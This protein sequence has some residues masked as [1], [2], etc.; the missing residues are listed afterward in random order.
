MYIRGKPSALHKVVFE[1][2]YRFGYTYLDR[3]GRTINAIMRES[4]EWVPTDQTSPQNTPLIS[5]INKSVFNFS[6]QNLNFAI[7]QPFDSEI[8]DR[9]IAHFKSQVGLVSRI[10]I[11]QLGL[12]EFI[13]IGFRAWY[14]FRCQTKQESEQWLRG[15]GLYSIPESLSAAFGDEIESV[16]LAAIIKGSDRK[17]RIS[18]NGVENLA[19]IDRGSE[20][21]SVRSSI[22]SKDQDKALKKHLQS[23]T[24]QFAAMI[25]ID[26][27]QDDPLQPDPGDFVETSLAQFL[28]RLSSAI[29]SK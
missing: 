18:F 27:F 24:T 3:C 20:I 10:V 13:R 5:F 6:S 21:I 28:N 9:D 23:R 4:P 2:R 8:E 22:L 16:G 25:D 26:A 14:V 7:E 12:S 29:S 1:L 17:F 11:D 15:L 19:Q